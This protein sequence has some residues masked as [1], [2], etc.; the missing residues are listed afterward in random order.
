MNQ[1]ISHVQ[2]PKASQYLQQLCKHFGHKVPVEFDTLNG[3]ITLPFGTCILFAQDEELVLTVAGDDIGKLE[4]VIGGHL[5]R[6][7]FRE[8]LNVTWDST[9]QP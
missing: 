6:F 5:E 9:N 3:S 1:S 2:T 8:S 7:A 4:Q